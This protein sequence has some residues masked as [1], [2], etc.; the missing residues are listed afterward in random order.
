MIV[1]RHIKAMKSKSHRELCT[2]KQRHA[3]FAIELGY[4]PCEPIAALGCQAMS[5]RNGR[6]ENCHRRTELL[7]HQPFADRRPQPTP[8]HTVSIGAQHDKPKLS[9]LSVVE[10]RRTDRLANDDVRLDVMIG[11]QRSPHDPTRNP[12]ANGSSKFAHV[13]LDVQRGQRQ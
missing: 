12:L 8:A 5:K 6:P 3:R 4:L 11:T 10:N 7:R 13:R 1:D 9:L 2:F